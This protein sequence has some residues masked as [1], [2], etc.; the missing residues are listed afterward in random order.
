MARQEIERAVRERII[1]I[2]TNYGAT[3]IA[4]FGSCARGEATPE[5]DIDILVRFDHPKSLFQLVR[6]EDE[7][8]DALHR[9]V[10]LVTEKSVSPHIA[11]PI[12]RD[13]VVIFG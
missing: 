5:S 4:I 1:S 11:G 3:R 9:H 6:I 2:L 10:D 12:R 7:L 13:E 8:A